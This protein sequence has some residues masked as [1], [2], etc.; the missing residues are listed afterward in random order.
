MAYQEWAEADY[1]R[2]YHTLLD[3]P[4]FA[5]VYDDDRRW[6][7]YTRLLIAADSTYPAPA[8]LPRGLPDDVLATLTELEVL[9]ILR[10]SHYRIKALQSERERRKT[11]RA[12]GGHARVAGAQRD[13]RGRL[14]AGAVAGVAGLAGSD[15]G[16]SNGPATAGPAS[17][18]KPSRVRDEKE[19]LSRENPDARARLRRADIAA[20]HDRGWKRVTKAQRAVLDE[21]LGRHDVTGP[22]FAAEAIR[23][24]PADKDPLEA[25]M[26][27]DRLWQDAQRRRADSDE[28]AWAETKAEERKPS[29]LGQVLRAAQPAASAID[30]PEWMTAKA[31][32]P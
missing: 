3:D 32:K 18:A 27:A 21:I 11:G 13:E 4:K 31:G 22:E 7:W 15:A 5:T 2:L 24:T 28:A 26:T 17:P 8:P 30:E 10:G 25:V 29:K 1:S 9:V 20:L 23:A 19:S 14:L 6:A 16:S 12:A